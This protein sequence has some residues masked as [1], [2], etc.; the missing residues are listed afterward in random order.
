MSGVLRIR[1]CSFLLKL[2]IK[3]II[4]CS[5]KLFVVVSQ[6]HLGRVELLGRI[7]EFVYFVPFSEAVLVRIVRKELSNLSKLVCNVLSCNLLKMI[8]S[9]C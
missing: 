6:L 4:T 1:E 7:T 2:I 8:S 3:V 9:S 5:L